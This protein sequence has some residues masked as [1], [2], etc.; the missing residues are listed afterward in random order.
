MPE[1][2]TLFG[3]IGRTDTETGIF[4]LDG[5]SSTFGVSRYDA[6]K[7]GALKDKY[8]ISSHEPFS[9]KKDKDPPDFLNNTPWFATKEHDFLLFMRDI[10]GTDDLD[11]N[12]SK[13]AHQDQALYWQL[14]FTK[15]RDKIFI[16]DIF[17][18]V[19]S[20]R[21]IKVILKARGCA[22][23]RII[24]F[25]S[26]ISARDGGQTWFVSPK[27]FSWRSDHH[28]VVRGDKRDLNA[29][30]ENGSPIASHELFLGFTNCIPYISGPKNRQP[31]EEY[32]R[33]LSLPGFVD[34][35][36]K[37][38]YGATGELISPMGDRTLK[39]PLGLVRRLLPGSAYEAVRQAPTK[40]KPS[41]ID[42]SLIIDGLDNDVMFNILDLVRRSRNE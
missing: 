34:E 24:L 4:V 27:G 37:G 13:F 18:I 20:A 22:T 15:L 30:D 5:P 8:A 1:L 40:E 2:S 31:D 3:R 23:K 41:L 28:I 35:D 16:N 39:I 42:S 14:R 7:L 26:G 11:G 38:L 17:G 32:P 6:K 19:P 9:E 33:L 21:F 12:F 29:L 10:L 36:Y 25:V